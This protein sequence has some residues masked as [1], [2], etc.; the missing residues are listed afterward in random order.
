MDD[1]WPKMQHCQF[2]TL[3]P[4]ESSHQ[5]RNKR[6]TS[7]GARTSPDMHRIRSMHPYALISHHAAEFA[8]IH[9]THRHSL[10]V[11]MYSPCRHTTL[12]PTPPQHASNQQHMSWPSPSRQPC[13]HA[14]TAQCTPPMRPKALSSHPAV[15]SFAQK[16]PQTKTHNPDTDTSTTRQQPTALS[17]AN[18]Q[19]PTMH[20]LR[21]ARPHAPIGIVSHCPP[22]HHTVCTVCTTCPHTY[23]TIH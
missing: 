1:S 18:P 15:Q 2:E 8:Q 6:T 3:W 19:S 17:L 10:H 13:M 16:P 21:S 5:Q 9:P 11:P 23:M 14:C 20:A 22:M 12:T 4:L 7:Y